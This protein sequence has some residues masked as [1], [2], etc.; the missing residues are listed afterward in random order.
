MSFCKLV[1]Q[2]FT[3][4]LPYTQRVELA[5]PLTDNQFLLV[6][7]DSKYNLYD[8][9]TNQEMFMGELRHTVLRYH[10]VSDEEVLLIG[11]KHIQSFS[12]RSRQITVYSTSLQ[13]PYS[14]L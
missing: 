9:I 14:N 4:V 2:H 1:Q 10:V 12:C 5:V 8:F 13:S 11:T 7:S 3:V 6:F